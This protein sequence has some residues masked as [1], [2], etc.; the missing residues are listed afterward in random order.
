MELTVG[1][2][3]V[4]VFIYMGPF[5]NAYHVVQESKKQAH[6]TNYT[7]TPFDVKKT[8]SYTEFVSLHINDKL[9]LGKT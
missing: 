3:L 2:Q 5:K 8:I 1:F 9:S 4:L 6:I 7:T